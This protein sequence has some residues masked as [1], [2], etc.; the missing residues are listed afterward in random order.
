MKLT[1]INKNFPI[2]VLLIL[3]IK[4]TKKQYVMTILLSI[5]KNLAPIFPN[6]NFC[7]GKIQQNRN[8]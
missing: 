1:V 4:K 2:E 3:Y 6:N 5:Q 8:N 7:K